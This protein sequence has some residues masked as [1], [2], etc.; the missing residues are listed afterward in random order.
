MTCFDKIAGSIYNTIAMKITTF[1]SSQDLISYASSILNLSYLQK[2]SINIA[3]SGGKTPFSM[4][5]YWKTNQT[6]DYTKTKVW[7]VDER[8]IEQSS[9]LSNAGK[10]IRLFDDDNFKDNFEKVNTDL[11]YGECISDYDDR[12]KLVVNEESNLDI[13]FLGFGTDGHFGSIFPGDDTKYG[14]QLAIGTLAIDPYPVEKRI[15]MTPRCINL[16]EK[17][18]AILVGAEK[19]M[20]LTEFLDGSLINS[21]FPCKIWKDHPNL[22]VL[23]CFQ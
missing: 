12:L 1:Q 8:Y 13:V 17:I 19:Q 3:I 16:A 2:E 20:V 18:V 22:E 10:T 14:E 15:T 5:E 7:Q 21:Q 6:I 23:I 9:D 4:F 11:P